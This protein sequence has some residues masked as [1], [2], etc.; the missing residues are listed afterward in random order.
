MRLAFILLPTVVLT[1]T[2]RGQTLAPGV[3]LQLAYTGEL[4]ADVSGGARRDVVYLD[5]L[6][7]TLTLDGESAVGWKGATLFLY[8]L[9]NHGG[10]PAEMIGDAQGVSNIE[11]P[12]SWRLHEAWI[13]QMAFEAHLSILA[14]L[15][16][17]SSEFDFIHAG[18]L[19]L[20]GSHGTGVE[21][22]QSGKN[23]P[24]IF[25][26]T[27]IGA[28]VRA[29]AGRHFHL[30]AAI[31]DGVPGDPGDVNGI[32]VKFGDDDGL[33][34][35]GE[36]VYTGGATANGIGR[37]FRRHFVSRSLHASFSHRFA[38]G[39][40]GY[41]AGF[42]EF[43]ETRAQLPG[44]L[45]R[46]NWGLYALGEWRAYEEGEDQGLSL[47]GRLG[48]ANDRINRFATYSGF[49]AVYHGALPGRDEDHLGFATAI[50]RNGDP[51]LRSIAPLDAD[52]AEVA[53]ELTY[54]ALV[55]SWLSGQISV[56]Y[57]INPNTDP[58]VA[59]AVV[60]SL[61]ILIEP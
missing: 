11:A 4:V 20:H 53:F 32:Q 25:P 19:F 35:I 31:V 10:S 30:K 58:T 13:E 1:A 48:F 16:D 5:N 51:Y 41:T 17:V 44:R 24:S 56:H 61:R 26:F 39:A 21:F 22:S 37:A 49:G 7:V 12:D 47:F 23:G 9:A 38:V 18:Q 34:W 43:P 60:P 57:I 50:A 29:I 55:T 15:Y 45:S 42:R 2:V 46:D 27:S 8:G 54:Q 36:L 52:R 6:D 33:M 14:G 40:W 28:R 3:D 59:N